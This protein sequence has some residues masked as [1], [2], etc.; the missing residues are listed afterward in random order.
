MENQLLLTLMKL[1]LNSPDL[2]L[3]YRFCISTATVANVFKTFVYALH[4][5]LIKGIMDQILPSS[6]K[7]QSSMPKCFEGFSQ[8]R[9][10]MDATEFGQDVPRDL[11]IQGISYSAYKSNHTMKAL[12]CVAP[13]AALVYASPL[14][15]GSASDVT[16]AKH[17]GILEKLS[18]GDMVIADKGFPLYNH[19]P[20]GVSLNIPPFLYNGQ[21][22]K[23]EAQLSAKIARARI[24]VERANERFKNFKIL[25]HIPS[26]YRALSTKI[27]QVCAYL[28]NLQDPLLKEISQNYSTS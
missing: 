15:F 23:S 13:N 10:I 25:D 6:L 27:F 11:N 9:L 8:A 16:L 18:P 24:H 1:R 7:C 26:H 28:V 17:C 5:L 21:F 3:A 12:T 22:T 20:P 19:I 4:E 14:Y 2:D